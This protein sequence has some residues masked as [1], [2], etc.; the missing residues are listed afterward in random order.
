MEAIDSYSFMVSGLPRSRTDAANL[1]AVVLFPDHFVPLCFIVN[2]LYNPKIVQQN[3]PNW[4]NW[5]DTIDVAKHIE[6]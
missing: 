5:L 6:H 4:F 2:V 3:G 1:F